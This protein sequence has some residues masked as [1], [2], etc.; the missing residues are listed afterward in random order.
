MSTCVPCSPGVLDGGVGPAP[1]PGLCVRHGDAGGEGGG[2]AALLVQRT[3]PP[4]LHTP[5]LHTPVQKHTSILYD[6]FV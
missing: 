6:M 4:G 1:R 3:R 5:G 2:A